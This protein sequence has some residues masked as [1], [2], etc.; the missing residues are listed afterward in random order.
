MPENPYE[1]PRVQAFRD[2]PRDNSDLERRVAE[3]EKLV[4]GSWLLR[5][6]PIYRVVAVWGYFLLG[7]A[8]L[9]AIG[10]FLVFLN[11]LFFKLLV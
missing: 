7:Y 10:L 6:S 5:R 9:G 4:E 11:W 3:L 8:T 2:T 1:T